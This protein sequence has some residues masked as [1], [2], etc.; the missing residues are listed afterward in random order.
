MWT[1]SALLN[2]GKAGAADPPPRPQ[3]AGAIT[4]SSTRSDASAQPELSFQFASPGQLLAVDFAGTP[5][6][7]AGTACGENVTKHHPPT[8][9]VYQNGL[10]R[11]IERLHNV[12]E[13]PAVPQPKRR[14]T[15]NE[16]DPT[17]LL[18]AHNSFSAFPG[19][20]TSILTQH[21]KMQQH[22]EPSQ[23]KP[24][25]KPS[26]TID[27]TGGDTEP[28]S[29]SPTPQNPAPKHEEVCYG[30]VEGASINCHRVPA[31]KPGMVSINGDGYWPQVKVVLKRKADDQTNRIYVYDH[32]RH[33]FGTVD[34]KTA[35]CL[36]PLLDS[37]LQIRTDC[38]IPSRR[39]L[40][41]EQVGQPAS[42]S[43]KFDLMVY[44][45]RKFANQVGNHMLS[46]KVNL[47]S[48]PRVE[49][50]V[51]VFNPMAAE[52]R[53]PTTSRL[54]SASSSNQHR[55]PPV[56]RT[57]EEIRS[58]V[59]GVFDS[60][61]KSEDLPEAEPDSRIQTTLLKH[62]RQALYFM[63]AR[64]AE[65]LPDSGK[66]LITSTW[67][68]KKDRFG[69]VV[70]YNVVTNQTQREPPPS[71][72]GG[73]LAD[74]MGLGKTL[75]VLS[76]VTKTLDAAERWSRLPPQ[77]PKAPERKPQ[78]PFQQQFEVPRP[79]AL[80]LTPLRQN[81]KATLLV[82]PLSTV[83]NW[84]EQIKQHIKPGSITYH[85]YHGPNRI[86]DV[87][88]LAQFDLVITTYGSVVS[89]LNSRSKRKQ[90][91]YPLEEIGWFRIVL[92]EAH[93][94]REQ[95][96]L[97]FKSICR[98]QANRRW[99]VTGTPVQ[100]KLEDLAALLAFLR[101]KPFDE[102]SK[103][104]QFII[105]PFKAADPE[106][107]PKLRVLIDT[108]TLRRLK[109]K[110]HLP[111]RIDEVVKLDFTP[112]ER[113]VYD[114]FAKT[115]QDRVRALTG[116]AIGQ[117]RI[118]GGRTMIHILRSILQLRLIC[119]HGKDL[120][121]DE[122]LADLQGMTADTPIDLD[123]DDDDEQ[124]VLSEKKAY[125]MLYL[126]Q[127]G[128][129][130]NCSRC[131]TKLGAIEVDD[132]ESDRQD[133]IL[134]YMARCFHTYCP[135]CVNLVRNEQTGCD[136]CAGL[137]KSSC[138]ELRRK[139]AEI[140]HESRVAKNKGGTNKIIPD[141]RYTGPHTKTRALI[142]ELLANKEK[143]AMHPNE[144]PFKSVVFSGW[145]SH[146]DLIQIALDNA[147][148]TYTRLDGKMSR[149]ARNAAMDA[150]REDKSVQVILVSLMAGGLGLNLTAGNT[151]Y[152]MEPQFNP[153]AEAQAVDRVHRLGQTR[154]VRTVRF[155]MKDSFEEKM[156][157]LQD[158]KKKLAS[159]SMDR[160][161]NDRV[162]DRT[163]AARQ[164]LMDL[165]SLF[166]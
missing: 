82:C 6:P 145:T 58:E 31:P 23:P 69:G 67:Q 39:K 3:S 32:T 55:P 154:C 134:G 42:F 64:E 46:K 128:N 54:S 89:E 59:L 85:I 29:Q 27:L 136:A 101:L 57:V 83:T 10:S 65:Q 5:T 166:K 35:E 12:Q 18:P 77:Q 88:Q 122:D 97:A 143:S 142:E 125:E 132:P 72:L 156:L 98:L 34:V 60:L 99:A 127:E 16:N 144:P 157:Q 120:L 52:N 37:A 44:G 8:M 129:S 80:G 137:V 110:I 43:C 50:G 90:G 66:A 51:K 95:N 106:I 138:V 48:P 116:Q 109:D 117:D 111:E 153:A 146:L 163:E 81:A 100:N 93:T 124:S 19:A 165:R 38:R 115:A 91:T 141:D 139:R 162:T 104:V 70:Y 15:T 30:M 26:E 121:S 158:K 74:M 11:S 41:G 161:P 149:P 102:R 33:I 87:A 45:P 86:K 103:F 25:Q 105:Q 24:A 73:I 94:I 36:V 119:A 47:V 114:W 131:N 9:P 14:K 107:V 68:R 1:P 164:R 21:L 76:L 56:V 75:S 4:G 126:M 84:E 20:G 123:R 155:I 135:S 108:I 147:G 61:P 71:T 40:P 159:L 113:Q 92:D 148:I 62:Q 28:A 112:E 78:H 160:D 133:D 152:V 150:F 130:D 22:A 96:T 17:P 2:P 13:R 63:T 79:A 53:L 7:S 118:V 151:V 140:E 49:S